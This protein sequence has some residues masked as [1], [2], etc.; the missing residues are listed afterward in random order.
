MRGVP[1]QRM[2]A[3]ESVRMSPSSW[4]EPH[5]SVADPVG[6][7]ADGH[8]VFQGTGCFVDGERARVGDVPAGAALFVGVPPSMSPEAYGGRPCTIS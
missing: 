5:L 3:A 7:K 8:V 1:P 6:E 2:G 4:D